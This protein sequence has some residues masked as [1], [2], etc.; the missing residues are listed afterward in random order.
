[1]QVAETAAEH[2]QLNVD[3]WA[4]ETARGLVLQILQQAISAGFRDAQR[5]DQD[6]AGGP[7]RGD[8]RF[9]NI[10]AQMTVR[11]GSV[12]GEANSA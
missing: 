12:G 7:F 10:K 3:R 9:L 5:F 11:D 8:E 1:V 4:V 6:E 2:G